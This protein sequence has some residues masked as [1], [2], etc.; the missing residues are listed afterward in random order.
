MTYHFP[1]N[2]FK[3]D[4]FLVITLIYKVFLHCQNK[5]LT[6]ASLVY[7][8]KKYSENVCNNKVLG[9][10]SRIAIGYLRHVSGGSFV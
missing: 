5:C 3:Y 7:D 6:N 10:L 9:Y 2:F 1:Y 4:I 8:T